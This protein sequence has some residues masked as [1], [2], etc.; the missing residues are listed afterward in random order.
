MIFLSILSLVLLIL[1]GASLFYL[2]RFARIIMIL[3]DDFSDAIEA[4]EETEKSFEK[5]LG[6]RLFFDSREVQMVVQEV[7]SEIKANKTT[8][9]RIALRFVERSKQKYT[10]VVEEEP[11]IKQLQEQLMR[12]RLLRGDILD[13]GPKEIL[14]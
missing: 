4:F 11:D 1:L 5:I 14:R 10:V 9:S 3:E 2:I 8:I 13:E 7:M 12:E 6:M